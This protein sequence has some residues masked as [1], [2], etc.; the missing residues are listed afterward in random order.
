MNQLPRLQEAMDIDRLDVSIKNLHT[1]VETIISLLKNDVA[2]TSD[3]LMTMWKTSERLQVAYGLAE[4]VRAEQTSRKAGQAL[5]GTDAKS[6]A[7]GRKMK[8]E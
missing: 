6:Q 7:A 3:Q 5:A 4:K 1:T 2:P 8:S